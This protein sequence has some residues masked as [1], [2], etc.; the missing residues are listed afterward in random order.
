METEPAGYVYSGFFHT[1]SFIAGVLLP[2]KF[3]K[4][5]SKKSLNDGDG[6]GSS[7]LTG[8]SLLR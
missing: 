8:K 5:E 1:L 7:K 4:Q 2:G 3:Q 6:Y